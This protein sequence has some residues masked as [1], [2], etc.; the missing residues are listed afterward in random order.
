[1]AAPRV[2]AFHG[3]LSGGSAWEPLR[4]QLAGEAELITPDLPG[5]GRSPEPASA[6]GYSLD[7]VVDQVKPLLDA[8]QPVVLLGHSMGAIVA[9]ALAARHPGAVRAVGIIG[10]PV[11]ESRADALGFLRG[12]RRGVDGLLRSD[13]MSHNACRALYR[14]RWAWSTAAS[15]GAAPY[16][17]SYLRAAFDHSQA[18]HSGSLDGIVF[19]GRVPGVAAAVTAPVEMLHPGGDRV[20]PL[21]R[22]RDLGHAHGWHIATVPGAHHQLPIL[23]PKVTARWVR[24]RLLDGVP[25]EPGMRSPDEHARYLLAFLLDWHRREDKAAWWEYYRLRELPEEDLLEEPGAVAGLEFVAEVRPVKKSF[26]QQYRYPPQEIEIH[27]GD[28]LKTQDGRKCGEAVRLDRSGRTINILVGPKNRLA[29]PTALFAPVMTRSPAG[30][31]FER[32]VLPASR[33]R[34]GLTRSRSAGLSAISGSMRWREK[35]LASSTVG[36]TASIGPGA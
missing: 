7:A 8:H 32:T 18:A 36:C 22:A 11:Y 24:A 4:R 33:E 10:I 35:R 17:G 19:S 25:D 6:D 26:E 28:T 27:S 9:L 23:R 30:N 2:L 31:S 14:T 34:A 16:P 29:R 3:F 1:M 13:R 21:D 20:A 5:Y 15:A 12:R